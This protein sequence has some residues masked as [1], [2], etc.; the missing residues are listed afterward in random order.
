VEITEEKILMFAVGTCSLSQSAYCLVP[1]SVSK[2]EDGESAPYTL[3][4]IT[5]SEC[6]ELGANLPKRQHMLYVPESNI[7]TPYNMQKIFKE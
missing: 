6:A 1:G 5:K 4:V 7:T 2:R 3:V